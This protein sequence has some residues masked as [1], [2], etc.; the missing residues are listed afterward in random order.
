M[1]QTNNFKESKA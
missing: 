1:K